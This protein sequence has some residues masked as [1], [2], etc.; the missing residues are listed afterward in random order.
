MIV[1]LG[2]PALDPPV[3]RSPQD[4]GLADR[5]RVAVLFQATALLAH[6]EA[7]G[8]RLA[9]AWSEARV[10]AHGALSGLAAVPGRGGEPASGCLVDLISRL[11][12]PALAGRG[13]AR[14]LARACVERWSIPIAPP[15]LDVELARLTGEAEFLLAEPWGAVRRA[16][17]SWR[18][19][20][21]GEISLWVAGPAAARRRLHEAASTFAAMI[22]LLESAGGAALWSGPAADAGA[23]SRLAAADRLY[24]LG[25]FERA[26]RELNGTAGPEAELL[27]A[28]SH[29]HLGRFAPS[30]CS[31]RRLHALGPRGATL[32]EALDLA[33]VVHSNLGEPGEVERWL[34]SGRAGLRGPLAPRAELAAAEAA[35][36]R[37]DLAKMNERLTAARPALDRPEL[38][39]RWHRVAGEL[40]QA[41][42]SPA[43][44]AA[45][46]VEALRLGRRRALP[47]RPAG[48]GWGSGTHARRPVTWQVPSAPWHTPRACSGD[49]RG[50]W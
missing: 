10:G 19:D 14:R 4:P 20:Q 29:R 12:G 35:L 25:R 44:S 3:G 8:W 24:R 42:G 9:T 23:E 1:E 37:G 45:A 21:A 18:R 11:F 5:E 26:L 31:L 7:A 46:F 33:T 36:D 27:R 13:P 47:S 50:L 6:L 2:H 32:A 49:A 15:A 17:V 41:A 28:A 22:A 16:L 39:W 30:A 48:S 34:R 38:A 43:Q 40:A